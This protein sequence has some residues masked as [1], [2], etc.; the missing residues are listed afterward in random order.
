MYVDATMYNPLFLIPAAPVVLSFSW[1][2][3]ELADP[4]RARVMAR[5]ADLRKAG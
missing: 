3:V 5:L 1:E 2:H 4:R